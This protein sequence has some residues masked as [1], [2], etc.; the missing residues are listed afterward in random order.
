[1]AKSIL[2]DATHFAI[3]EPTGVEKYVDALLIPLSK[4][5]LQNPQTRVTWVGHVPAPAHVPDAVNWLQDNYLKGWGQHGAKRLMESGAF[6]VYFTPSGI[7]PL[8]GD[9]ERIMTVHDL[10]FI[11]YPAAYTWRQRWR[12]NGWGPKAA[13]LCSHVIVPTVTVRDDVEHYWKVPT[14]KINVVPHGPLTWP[15]QGE[16]VSWLPERTPY[17]YFLGRIEEKKN[18]LTVIKAFVDIAKE[19]REL[20]LVLAGKDGYGSKA[21]RQLIASLSHELRS[22]I[23]LPGYISD[24]QAHWLMMHTEALLVPSPAEGF[25]F[26]VLDGFA[27]GIPVIT[28]HAGGAAEVGGEAVRAVQADDVPAWTAALREVLSN[29]EL[30]Q[31]MVAKGKERLGSF[32]WEQT[33]AHTAEILLSQPAN[34]A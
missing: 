10:S 27:V 28:A 32:S 2:I 24:E 9:F 25:A 34:R 22:R 5:L 29:K 19:H 31:Q 20:A 6:D 26:P 16:P 12:L 13:K 7:A 3:P 17:L 1:M 8:G 21:V 30:R 4:C 11:Q 14:G 23:F 15:Y 18:L 33:A